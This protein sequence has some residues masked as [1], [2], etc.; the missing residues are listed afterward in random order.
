MMVR[1]ASIFYVKDTGEKEFIDG[2]WGS[3]DYVLGEV[4]INDVIIRTLHM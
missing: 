2:L 3:V 4:V 1:I